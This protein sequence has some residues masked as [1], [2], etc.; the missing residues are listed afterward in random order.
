MTRDD[1]ART[2]RV[3]RLLAVVA[4]VAIGSTA[5]AGGALAGHLATDVKSYTGCLTKDGG[6]LVLVREGNAPAKPCASGSVQAHF[7]GGDITAVSAGTGLVGGGTNGALTLSLDPAFAL[8]QDC[9]AGDVVKWDG[10][11]WEC[12]DD[13]DTTYSAGEGLE[14]DGTTFSLDPDYGLPQDCSLGESATFL[15]DPQAAFGTWGCAQKADA[16]EACPDGEFAHAID[17]FGG[18]E[19]DEP[20]GGGG[21]AG[22]G[23]FLGKQVN[24]TQGNIFDDHVGVPSDGVIRVY[25]SVAVPA[26][27]YVVL[28]KGDFDS[29]GNDETFIVR[30]HCELNGGADAYDYGQ[31]MREVGY[32]EAFSLVDLAT[33]TG[34]TFTLTCDTLED[35]ISLHQSRIVAIK[36]G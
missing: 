6:T 19:C 28:A 29:E 21:G 5:I 4:A 31:Q 27:T 33:T 7:S 36:V 1:R 10:N 25:A 30:P 3:R 14:L 34:T 2:P 26:G 8:R 18:L 23:A 15:S 17:E 12:A 20:A 9:A 11:S 22:G 24:P 13:D 35:G 32:R 16:D